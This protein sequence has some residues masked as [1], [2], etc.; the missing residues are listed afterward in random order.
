M[1]WRVGKL[2]SSHGD[3]VLRAPATLS[4]RFLVK[5][6]KICFLRIIQRSEGTE[7]Y[8]SNPSATTQAFFLKENY[9]V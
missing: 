2:V 5:Y 8:I 7:V 4:K 3:S 1:K 9:K 6:I